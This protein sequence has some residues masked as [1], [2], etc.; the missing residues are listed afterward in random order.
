MNFY[1][2]VN[3]LDINIAFKFDLNIKK[4]FIIQRLLKEWILN[5]NIKCNFN[6]KSLN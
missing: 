2:I 3:Y 4:Y 1:V 5:K 6:Y